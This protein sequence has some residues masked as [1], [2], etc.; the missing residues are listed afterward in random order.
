MDLLDMRREY[1]AFAGQWMYDNQFYIDVTVLTVVLATLALWSYRQWCRPKPQG[2]K[3]MA[4]RER[5]KAVIAEVVTNAIDNAYLADRLPKRS[6]RFWYARL[7]KALDISDLQPRRTKKPKKINAGVIKD[8]IKRLAIAANT[9]GNPIPGPKPGEHVDL[10][11]P[12]VVNKF[13]L[14]RRFG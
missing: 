3:G 13:L 12:E 14:K 5:Q 11:I 1:T 2:V 8:K 10:P 7:A 9:P 4:E 6:R